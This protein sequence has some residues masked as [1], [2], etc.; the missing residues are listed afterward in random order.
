MIRLLTKRRE[1]ERRR[2]AAGA[3]T[4]DSAR[5]A[6]DAA[7]RIEQLVRA[8]MKRRFARMAVLAKGHTLDCSCEVCG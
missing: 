6:R 7:T 2:K 1:E 3:P 5:D 8:G 4:G